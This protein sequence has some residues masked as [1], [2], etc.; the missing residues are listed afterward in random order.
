MIDE[1]ARRRGQPVLFLGLLVAGWFLL[2]LVTWQ[3]PWLYPVEMVPSSVEPESDR[4][5]PRAAARHQA[6][7]AEAEVEVDAAGR[8]RGQARGETPAVVPHHRPIGLLPASANPA[9]GP[10]SPWAATGGLRST[11][12]E[13]ADR[14]AER[15]L[16]GA[17][18][19]PP[20]LP[21]ARSQKWRFDG[22]LMLRE[23]SSSATGSGAGPASYGASQAGA[24]L[25]YRLASGLAIAPAL[26]ARASRAL[27]S[28]DES[29]VAAGV[30]IRP[31]AQV[32]LDAHAEIRATA[33][34]SA[35]ELRPAMFVAGG[36]DGVALPA[37]LTA[38]GYGQAGWV[39][40][41]YATGFVDGRAVIDRQI[42][43]SERAAVALGAGVWGGA[44]R[45]GGRLD[46]GPSMRFDLR[47][48]GRN[49]RIAVDY[50][51][52]VAGAAEPGS[53]AVLTLST[54]F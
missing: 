3:D 37:R 32:P 54:G 29:E 17:Q 46:L 44:Q 31:I 33:R 36:F 22:W 10:A 42:G 8:R 48:A 13:A 25:S 21:D 53:G 27:G 51:R 41:T 20:H 23:G 16:V 6:A 11:A 1:V 14:P 35:T 19:R 2:R 12:Q 40:G 39:G 34:G 18:D 9:I 28:S 26:F 47:L 15:T 52:R 4:G 7:Q 50:R 38:S 5:A 45:G 24:L 49:A 30:R 43:A